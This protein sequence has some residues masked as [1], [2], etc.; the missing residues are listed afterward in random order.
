MKPAIVMCNYY[1]M[2]DADGNAIGH[3]PKVTNEYSEMLKEKFAL[4]LAAS[5]CIVNACNLSGFKEVRSL[6][7]DICAEGNTITKRIV[8][9]IKL[10]SNISQIVG[11]EGVYFFYQV[12]FFFFFYMR[13]FYR[14]THRRKIICLVYHQDF[15]GG[16]LGKK[17]QRI[18]LNALKKIDGVVYTQFEKTVSHPNSIWMPD[19]LYSD[20][21]YRRYQSLKKEKQV[22][23]MGT[24]NRYKQ[25]EQLVDIFSKINIPLIIAGRFDDKERF[26]NLIKNKTKNIEIYDAIL[27]EN[28]YLEMIATSQYSILPYDMDQYVS[29]TSGVL[30]ESIY[31]GS[32]PIAPRELLIQNSLPGIGYN[33]MQD[34]LDEKNWR[35]DITGSFEKVYEKNDK[36]IFMERLIRCIEG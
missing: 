4:S 27:P 34:L 17:L 19:F 14:R 8:D 7:Y 30:L 6:K 10:V 3:A 24:M 36:D 26:R 28:E 11:N 22:V 15:T 2:C 5:P 21:K 25:L 31:L 23:C 9:K 29:R 32:I 33:E 20:E 35:E 16:R 1:G 13:F 18:Y 12:D